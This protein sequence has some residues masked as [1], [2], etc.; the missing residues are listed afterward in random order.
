MRV[1]QAAWMRF[2]ILL[3]MFATCLITLN[4]SSIKARS[5]LYSSAV[6]H[7]CNNNSVKIFQSASGFIK[8]EV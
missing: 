2:A 1:D 6:E 8:D 3:K 5:S 4:L 7:S